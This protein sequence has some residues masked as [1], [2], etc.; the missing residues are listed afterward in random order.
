[1]VLLRAQRDATLVN[2]REREEKCVKRKQDTSNCSVLLQLANKLTRVLQ[3]RL[4]SKFYSKPP[5]QWISLPK[6]LRAAK[7]I[8]HLQEYKTALRKCNL[9]PPTPL[10]T[11]AI[12][13]QQI[14]QSSQRSQGQHYG[15]MIEHGF[16]LSSVRNGTN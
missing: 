14:G 2:I 3:P 13:P 12:S 7:E 8:N 5:Q 11:K 15:F 9:N 1:M 6:A 16:V 4:Q 10:C